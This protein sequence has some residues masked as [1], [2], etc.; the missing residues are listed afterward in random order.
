MFQ[1]QDKRYI[2][3]HQRFISV[4]SLVEAYRPVESDTH[5]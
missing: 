3:V 1:H 2:V 5:L 4:Q